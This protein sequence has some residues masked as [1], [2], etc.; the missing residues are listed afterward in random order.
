MR[1]LL[2]HFSKQNT[3]RQQC[4][5]ISQPTV[6]FFQQNKMTSQNKRTL[7]KIQ[8]GPLTDPAQWH[9]A[10]WYTGR[11]FCIPQRAKYSRAKSKLSHITFFGSVTS[12]NVS[13]YYRKIT[14]IL[15]WWSR[16]AVCVTHTTWTNYASN[17]TISHLWFKTD[18]ERSTSVKIQ[19]TGHE[20]HTDLGDHNSG[21]ASPAT[22]LHADSKEDKKTKT[23]LY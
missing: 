21:A 4:E 5:D 9:T 23:L 16:S 15:A 12:H 17:Y 20:V 18:K 7:N 1:H 19:F 11:G 2:L 10:N 3:T 14:I 8:H 22:D 13:T 6:F